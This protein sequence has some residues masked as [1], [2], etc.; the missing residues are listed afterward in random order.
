LRKLSCLIVFLAFLLPGFAGNPGPRLSQSRWNAISKGV[1][2][3]ETFKESK[4]DHRKGVSS[5]VDYDFRNFKYIFY[6]VVIGIMAFLIIKI[7]ANFRQGPAVKETGIGLVSIDEIEEK[8]HE[9]NL[10]DLFMEALNAKNF[11]V[12]L[13]I[14]FLIIIKILSKKGDIV[15]AKKK[16]NWEYYSELNDGNLSRQFKAIIL[17]FESVWYGEHLLTEEQ[18]NEVSPDYEALI[19]QLTVNE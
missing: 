8:I 16:T 7:L 12:A 5:P 19:K 15:W 1:D 2:Y 3:T 14:K 11:K 6:T 10:D 18:F 13:R 4:P 9:I 17:N